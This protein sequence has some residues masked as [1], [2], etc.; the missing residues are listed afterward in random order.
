VC[1]NAGLKITHQRT[2]IFR[3]VAL[4]LDHPD[5]DGIYHSIHK[6]LPMIS[7]DTIYRTLWL[8]KDLGLIKT[9]GSSRERTRFDANLD[10]HH[11]FVCLKCVMI[12]DFYSNELDDL[13]IPDSINS[14][15]SATEAH[16][17]VQGIC[18]NCAPKEKT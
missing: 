15:G 14:Y 16:V 10:R 11:H 3:E 12:R 8:L 1:R 4:R 5:A 7:L 6:R 2:E 18:F 13:K 17:E 9:L